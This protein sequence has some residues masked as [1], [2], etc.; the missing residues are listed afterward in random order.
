MRR[1]QQY[2]AVRLQQAFKRSC[3]VFRSYQRAAAKAL[4]DTAGTQ[5]RR[6]IK[7][8]RTGFTFRIVQWR[9]DL[10]IDVRRSSAA[11]DVD[12]DVD[13]PFWRAQ[14]RAAFA[15]GLCPRGNGRL[16]GDQGGMFEIFEGLEA[17]VG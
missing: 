17:A 15:T 13:R 5:V 3:D 7:L 9:T 8:A 11:V 1:T 2:V 12:V 14:K 6:H 4:N 16:L 10:K